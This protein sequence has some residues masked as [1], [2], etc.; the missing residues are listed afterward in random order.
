MKKIILLLFLVGINYTF[1]QNS[2][3]IYVLGD[4]SRQPIPNVII[5]I[6]QLNK[7]LQTDTLGALVLAN[8]TNGKYELTFSALGFRSKDI[9]LKTPQADSNII[10]Y[11]DQDVATM[12]DV[13]VSSTRTNRLLK[14]TPMNVQVVSQEDI[15]EGTGQSP[16]NIRE[17][18][19]ELSGTQM[20]QTS[21]VSGNVAIRLQGLDGR[22]TQMLKDGFPLYGGFSGS[23]SILQVPPLDLKQVEVIKGVGSALYGGD[24]IAGIINL[25]SKQPDTAFHFDAIINQTNRSGTDIGTFISQR[26]K[27]FGYTLMGTWSHQQPKDINA[28]GF[29]DFPKVRQYLIAPTLFWYPTDSTTIRLGMNISTEN[30]NGGDIQAV[31]HGVNDQNAFLQSNH[32]DRD[33]YQLSIVHKGKD[34]QVFSFKNSVGYF[35]RSIYQTSNQPNIGLT[36]TGFSG[37]EISSFTEASYSVTKGV[38]QIVTGIGLNTDKFI[39]T[40]SKSQ[41]GYSYQTLGLFA[42]DNYNIGKKSVLELGVRTDWEKTFYFLPRV[43]ILYRPVNGLAIRLGGGMAYK[44][45]TIF[46]STDEEDAYQQVLPIAAS[47]KAER[48]ASA[49]LSFNYQ[50]YI[51]DDIRFV[52]DQ[53]LYYTRLSHALIPQLDS[54]QKGWLY[55]QNAPQPIIAKGSETS[56][57]FT[58]EDFALYMGYSYTDAR[59]TYL[60]NSPQLPITPRNRFVSTLTYEAEPHWKIGAEAFYTGNQVLDDGQPAR[61]FWTFDFTAQY[62]IHHCSFIFNIENI[63]DSRQSRFDPLFSGSLQNPIFKEVYAPIEGRVL[64]FAFRYRL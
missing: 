19:T 32:S 2:I 60:P 62:T 28:D 38:H 59:R 25:V 55:Y 23:L 44:L 47:V 17:L 35:Y 49:N 18:L 14:N 10:V 11:L 43:G 52:I 26:S 64:S 3:K 48:S 29:T 8:M 1:A 39:P 24:A 56:A 45:P 5:K 31:R 58:L 4:E 27:R 46:N 51:G 36:T 9:I 42:Q 7:A 15:E 37:S 30:R 13:V 21:A 63:S 33:Y 6:Q 16:A 54:L 57:R 20:Q 61:N 12:E 22:Y 40:K 41:L 50:G 34:Q 53:N